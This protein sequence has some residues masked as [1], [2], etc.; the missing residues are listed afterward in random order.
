MGRMLGYHDSDELDRPELNKCPDCECYFA[1]EACPL[2]GKLCPEDMRAG[3]RAPV[4]HKKRKNSSG[5]V[6]FVAWYHSW[7][8]IL[9]MMFV[10]PVVGV[11]LFFTSPYSKTV[12][13]IGAVAGI[14]YFVLIYGG[15]LW[16]IINLMT[17]EGDLVNDDISQVEYM[18]KCESVS[19][20]DFYRAG[21]STEGDYVTMTVVV[22]ERFSDWYTSYGE[23]PALY[24][25]CYD[26]NHPDMVILVRD[27]LIETD[28]NFAAGDHLTVFGESGGQVT[29]A[30]DGSS[31]DLTYPCL[32]MAYV[33]FVTQ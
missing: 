26:K 12:K 6:Q 31:A 21:D 23:E 3:H 7:W 16:Q 22:K 10:M 13:I 14:A 27:C 5:R 8:F 25:L 1:T 2:C 15:G 30:K 11:I 18:E 33:E 29:V 28:R 32:Y 19:V 4:K 24:Y 20:V 9:I 17:A